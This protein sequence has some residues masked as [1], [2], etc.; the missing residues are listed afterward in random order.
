MKAEET[1]IDKKEINQTPRYTHKEL[2]DGI[3]EENRYGETDFGKDVGKEIV[4][5]GI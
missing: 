3:A 2:L 4:D 1:D 5:F